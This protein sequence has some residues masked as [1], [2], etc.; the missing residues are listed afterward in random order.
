MFSRLGPATIWAKVALQV[1]SAAGASETVS[2]DRFYS[3]RDPEREREIYLALRQRLSA[4]ERLRCSTMQSICAKGSA[5]IRGAYA[6]FT[7]KLHRGVLRATLGQCFAGVIFVSCAV[8]EEIDDL[9]E[10]FSNLDYFLA[11][12]GVQAHIVDLRDYSMLTRYGFHPL[13]FCTIPDPLYRYASKFSRPNRLRANYYRK[14]MGELG[15]DSFGSP[16]PS[17]AG[18]RLPWIRRGIR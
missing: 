7:A 10:V 16:S 15:Y 6:I 11:P 17:Y 8:L 4:E 12:G 14:K 1:S 13:E 2:V 9:D 18:G 5:S 3:I